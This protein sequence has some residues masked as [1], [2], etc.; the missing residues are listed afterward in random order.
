[1]GRP[2]DCNCHCCPPVDPLPADDGSRIHT[3][4]A[5]S[6]PHPYTLETETFG[7]AVIN[8]AAV[9]LIGRRISP[10]ELHAAR[11]TLDVTA[12][13]GRWNAWVI[14]W[15][16][17]SNV[18]LIEETDPTSPNGVALLYSVQTAATFRAAIDR[19]V[20]TGPYIV[21]G[22]VVEYDGVRYYTPNSYIGEYDTQW[23]TPQPEIVKCWKNRTRD[24]LGKTINATTLEFEGDTLSFLPLS[25]PETLTRVGYV[26]GLTT[27]G[28][29]P[30]NDLETPEPDREAAGNIIAK[31]D[32]DG[33]YAAPNYLVDCASWFGPSVTTL[34]ATIDVG[35]VEIA[36]QSITLTRQSWGVYPFHR[37]AGAGT[38]T[39][40]SVTYNFTVTYS[41]CGVF[42]LNLLNCGQG[43][44]G[45]ARY[46]SISHQ[47]FNATNEHGYL[48]TSNW[49]PIAVDL[50]WTY[51]DFT[52]PG[53]FNGDHW[54]LQGG[55]GLTPNVPR[56]NP[57][58]SD[59]W[60]FEI[61]ITE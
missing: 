9:S 57:Y 50:K 20:E 26:I 42:R 15:V 51:L 43:L 31:L 54:W 32:L 14:L 13:T 40:L 7:G 2:P 58:P 59:G 5:E 6:L 37:Y 16:P 41:P 18:A 23:P 33:P 24:N 48:L 34:T 44:S 3:W 39:Y 61:S 8:S 46:I 17:G 52:K 22:S 30:A 56:V 11:I 38:Y 28:E 55:C 49:A 4:D 45:G 53:T 10:T 25:Q 27:A 12:P 29:P 21:F 47:Q 1:M 35:P 60:N 36:G 19:P